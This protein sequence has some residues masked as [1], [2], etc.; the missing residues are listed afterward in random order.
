MLSRNESR[1]YSVHTDIPLQEQ[2]MR[3]SKLF[4]RFWHKADFHLWCDISWY[5]P[6]LK[7]TTVESSKRKP[8]AKKFLKRQIR[9]RRFYRRLTNNR[10]FIG[11]LL[12][13][14]CALFSHFTVNYIQLIRV[15]E[16]H[17]G[18]LRIS[19]LALP[20]P[21]SSTIAVVLINEDT[22]ATLP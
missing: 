9:L 6:G 12:A 20:R 19:L 17:F 21:Q 7:L 5:V 10:W 22:L 1:L 8:F 3:K 2:V 16:N 4:F 11:L 15:A 18:D 13:T 14:I